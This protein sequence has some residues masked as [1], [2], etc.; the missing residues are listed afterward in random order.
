MPKPLGQ[1]KVLD[2]TRVLAG[3]YCTMLLKEL[4]AEIIKVE[5]PMIG[6]DAR[7]FG[8]FKNN[9]SLYFMSINHGKESIS[10]NL[11]T[12][13]GKRIL[14]E[15]V[16]QVDVLVEN[17]RPGTMEKLG[18]GYELL[19]E[20]NPRL[21]YAASSGFGHTGPDSQKPAYD[22]LVQAMG[23]I[24]SI[25]GWPDSPPTRVGMSIGDI[26]AS[27][28][29]A[30]GICSALYQRE[31]TGQGQKIDVGMLDC[32]VAILENALV[33]YQV[34]GVPPKPLGNRHPTITPF[35]AF[36]AKDDYIVIPVGNDN[37]WKIFCQAIG[38]EDLIEHE[39]FL[40]NKLRTEHLETLIPLLEAEIIKKT[41]AEWSDIF[42]RVGLPHSPINTIDKVMT[43]RQILARN[44]IV[45]IEDK[46][47]GAIKIAG[48][49]IKMTSIEEETTRKPAP[50]I[51]EHTDKILKTFLGYSDEQIAE[52]R[53]EG[54][55]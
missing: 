19:K 51:G 52:L 7:H 48:N 30:I 37:L 45:E 21:I 42:E 29:T 28:F 14:R 47:V 40:T 23:G 12:E 49:P 22:M 10:I 44:M 24:I 34:D 54:V 11:K 39:Q 17:F 1:V 9:K 6:D 41:V 3:P 25:T 13:Q 46:D 2:L 55:I 53:Q 18:L 38:R 4:G 32:Q 8:P 5:V 27:L 36:K 35:Q 16:Q 33:R 50:E 15:L 20:L 43:N 31:H 26:T